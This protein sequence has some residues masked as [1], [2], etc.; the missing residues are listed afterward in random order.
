VKIIALTAGVAALAALGCMPPAPARIIEVRGVVHIVEADE[1][2]DEWMHERCFYKGT[3]VADSDVDA[4]LK[5]LAFK[6]NVVE[7]LSTSTSSNSRSYNGIAT[8]TSFSATTCKIFYCKA[9]P[10]GI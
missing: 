10:E 1:D 5:A 7:P 3:I 2:G 6:A 4:R 8:S 9:L